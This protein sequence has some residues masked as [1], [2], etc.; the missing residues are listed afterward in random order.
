MNTTTTDL[1]IEESTIN[2]AAEL[3]QQIETVAAGKKTR[4]RHYLNNRDMMEEV[5]KSKAQGRLT[6][7]LGKMFILLCR[8]YATR[9]NLIG[10]SYNED[11]QSAAIL[12]LCRT[13]A[14]FNEEKSNNP[15]AYYTQCIKNSF[16]YYLNNEK[17][18]RQVRDELR[19]QQGLDPSWNYQQETASQ[20]YD[21][22]MDATFTDDTDTHINGIVEHAQIRNPKYYS[23][24]MDG[25]IEDDS[26]E[27]Q[28]VQAES[29]IGS[30][31]VEE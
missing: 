28:P 20:A 26:T 9:P 2:E 13:W 4:P 10:Y 17:R 25:D 5:R 23:G 7:N 6:E 15:F 29:D 24:E 14:S 3:E 8:R 30:D 19:V 16:N 27:H 21:S 31:L 18:E 1:T 11:M 22:A 12:N